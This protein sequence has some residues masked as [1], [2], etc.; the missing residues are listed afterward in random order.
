[1][2]EIRKAL[3]HGENNKLDKKAYKTAVKIEK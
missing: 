3:Y 1:M 2:D